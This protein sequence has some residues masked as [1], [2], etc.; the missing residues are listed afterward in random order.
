MRQNIVNTFIVIIGLATFA[1]NVTAEETKPLRTRIAISILAVVV[2]FSYVLGGALR[3]L[4]KLIR[5]S[6]GPISSFEAAAKEQERNE[7]TLLSRNQDING[8]K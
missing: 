7:D 6:G 4:A 5:H 1:S 8:Q 2:T 3:V